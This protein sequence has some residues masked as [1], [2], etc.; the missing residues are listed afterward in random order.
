MN[1]DDAALF[2]QAKQLAN[3]GQKQAAYEQLCAIRANG[4]DYDPDLLLWLSF[5]SPYQSEAQ[6]ALDTAAR[7]AP[8]HLGLSNARA[9]LSRRWQQQEYPQQSY[10]PQQYSQQQHAQQTYAPYPQQQYRPQPYVQP[11]PQVF[12]PVM[13]VIPA[14]QCPYCH[15]LAPPII[16][17]RIST[18][19]W[20]VFA[21]L[22][23]FTFFFCWIGLLIKE[24]Y[25]VC[26]YC[27]AQ[28]S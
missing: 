17:R 13:P 1:S 11:Y 27:G 7:I 6:D 15:T 14:G 16:K 24:D 12:V 19:G 3:A 10:V 4:N 26:S 18:A 9:Y 25:R 23:F 21:V 2:Q 8:D 5:T 22:F 20:V 28:L